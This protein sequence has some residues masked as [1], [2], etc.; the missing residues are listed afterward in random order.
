V[1]PHLTDI[2]LSDAVQAIR[3]GLITATDAGTATGSPLRFELG[4]I[5][6]EFTVELRRDTRA[7]GGVKAWV[8]DA[9]AEAGRATARTHKVSFTLKPVNAATGTGWRI[10]ADTEG[11]ASHFTAD[12]G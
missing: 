9:A 7:K 10:A 5:H 6:L 12:G 3:D 11:D 1:D 8:I 2:E 4:D